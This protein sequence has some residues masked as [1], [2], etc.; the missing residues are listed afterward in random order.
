MTAD[1]VVAALAASPGFISIT[2]PAGTVLWANRY[3][4]G[5]TPENIIGGSCDAT[6][7]PVD[8]AEFAAARRRCL[9][10]GETIVGNLRMLTL[11][12]EAPVLLSFRM[13][14]SGQYVVCI[15]WD[16]GGV[17]SSSPFWSPLE[18]RIIAAV[19]PDPVAARRLAVAAGATYNS[20]FRTSLARLVDAGAIRRI[21]RGYCLP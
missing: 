4:Y 19:G 1:E 17:R 20:R 11:I 7:H 16:I 3:G 8:R 15:T 18:R 5:Y 21:S 14:G 10:T 13:S 12:D 2:D 6:I 9:A